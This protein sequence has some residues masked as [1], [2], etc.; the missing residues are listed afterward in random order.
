MKLIITENKLRDLQINYLNTV[1]YHYSE[2]DNFKILYYP[3][4]YNEDGSDG[5]VM[6]E[7]DY[8]DGRLYI[9]QSFLNNFA[10]TYFANEDDAPI[11]I[12]KWFEDK[13][14]DKVEYIES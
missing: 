12:G 6:M 10:N 14:G 7:Y 8:E 3:N 2:F 1:L 4:S 13:F 11:V 5:E 9:D